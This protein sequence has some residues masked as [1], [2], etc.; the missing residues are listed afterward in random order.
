MRTGDRVDKD[1]LKLDIESLTH[2]PDVTYIL[3]MQRVSQ[4]L[5]LF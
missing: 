5:S 2:A 3:W 4:F 1:K